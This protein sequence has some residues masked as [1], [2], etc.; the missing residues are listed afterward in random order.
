[1]Q[2][3]RHN[4]EYIVGSDLNPIEDILNL[5]SSF[6]SFGFTSDLLKEVHGFDNLTEIKKLQK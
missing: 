5:M 3:L 4:D 6:R 2:I 1:M